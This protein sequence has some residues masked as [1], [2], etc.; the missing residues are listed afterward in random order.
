MR[1]RDPEMEEIDMDIVLAQGEAERGNAGVRDPPPHHHHPKSPTAL[2]PAA[3]TR[4]F[5]PPL[6]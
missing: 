3:L 1:T 6:P 5:H 4:F 2:S